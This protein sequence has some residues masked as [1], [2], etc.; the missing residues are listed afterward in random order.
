MKSEEILGEKLVERM[1]AGEDVERV[2]EE[3]ALTPECA[4]GALRRKDGRKRLEARLKL[5]RLQSELL[6][7]RFRPRAMSSLISLLGQSEKPEVVLKAA[8][9]LLQEDKGA[10]KKERG[11]KPNVEEVSAEE[12]EALVR[13]VQG[14]DPLEG[15]SSGG[16]NAGDAS[17]APN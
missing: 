8:L 16:A 15:V 5:G 9:S 2:L 17:V 7:A 14:N 11:K 13:L 3:M 12:L 1:V 10:V 6:K 4:L